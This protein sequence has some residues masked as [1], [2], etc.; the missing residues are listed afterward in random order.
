M[1]GRNMGWNAAASSPVTQHHQPFSNVGYTGYEAFTAAANNA[2]AAGGRPANLTVRTAVPATTHG[3][4]FI[5][6]SPL[7]ITHSPMSQPMSSPYLGFSR[8][9]PS[10]GLE[11]MQGY[12]DAFQRQ[13][14]QHHHLQVGHGGN[15]QSSGGG[16]ARWPNSA[17]LPMRGSDEMAQLDHQSF[18]GG[19]ES[20]MGGQHGARQASGGGGGGGGFYQQAASMAAG[21]VSAPL[22]EPVPLPWRRNA[23]QSGGG[24][25]ARAEMQQQQ[26]Q[27]RPEE[28]QDVFPSLSGLGQTRRTG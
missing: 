6:G 22:M 17:G 12:G 13:Q 10:A 16:G 19:G 9:P 4:R 3:Q 26:Q 23:P 14:Q 21:P 25:G 28:G 8:G 27:A 2:Y 5:S 18:M 1:Q 15:R 24:H 20:F 11:G 7:T